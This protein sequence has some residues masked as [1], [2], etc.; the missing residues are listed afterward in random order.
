MTIKSYSGRN[1]ELWFRAKVCRAGERRVDVYLPFLREKLPYLIPLR[2]RLLQDGQ[3]MQ[4]PPP[5]PTA[6]LP[7]PAS[8]PATTA[9]PP[10]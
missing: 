1:D 4:T 3:I 6:P 7:A 5:P 9:A 2:K 8:P 10:T